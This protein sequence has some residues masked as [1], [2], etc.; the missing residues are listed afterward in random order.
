MSRRAPTG[1]LAT[2]FAKG[3]A[4]WPGAR[5]A[6]L[7][8]GAGAVAGL[9]HAPLYLW[10]LTLLGL[11]AL[12]RLVAMNGARAGWFGLLGGAG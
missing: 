12:I 3:A 5:L 10:P 11:A 1:W 4:S 7:A 8:F 6:A 9:G 2:R